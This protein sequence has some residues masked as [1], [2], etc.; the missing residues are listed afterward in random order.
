MAFLMIVV[1]SLDS[2]CN[3]LT[4]ILHPQ[5]WSHQHPLGGTVGTRTCDIK[6]QITSQ[7]ETTLG[8]YRPVIVIHIMEVNAI[9][10]YKT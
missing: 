2:A 5:K 9:L 1:S 3:A 10:A 4:K 8:N 6:V 7:L